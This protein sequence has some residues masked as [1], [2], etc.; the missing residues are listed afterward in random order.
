MKDSTKDRIQGKLHETK[1]KIK[2]VTGKAINNPRVAIEGQDEK[3]S[4]KVQ[5]K[6]GQ[7]KRVFEK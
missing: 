5:E 7:T 1:G 3:I 2:E 4:G 6:V